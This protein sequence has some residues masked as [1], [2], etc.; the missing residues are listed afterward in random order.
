MATTKSLA[1]L[2]KSNEAVLIIK[3]KLLPVLQRLA[4]DSFGEAN[5]SAQASVALSIGMMKY[6]GA[7]LRGL[8]QGKKP[9][10]PLRKDLNNIKRVLANTKKS[11]AAVT[12]KANSEVKMPTK[13]K[14]KLVTDSPLAESSKFKRKNLEI[15][16]KKEMGSKIQKMKEVATSREK[17]SDAKKRKTKSIANSNINRPDSASK[18]SKTN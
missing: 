6:M 17:F 10:D 18:K 1:S 16:Q 2:E 9:D 7:R 5:G 12:K 3:K 13:V 8:D 14:S 15:K 11:R 4:D